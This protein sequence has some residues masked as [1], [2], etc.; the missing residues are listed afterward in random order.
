M[1]GVCQ[2]C[3][4]NDIDLTLHHLIP[5]TCHDNSWFKKRY[6]LDYMKSQTIDVC[7]LCHD[8]IHQIASEKELGRSFNSLDLIKENEEI[9]KF[10]IF[11][12]KQKY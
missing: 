11:A 9:K 1:K 12:R 4:R 5:K 8:K 2:I 7:R 10:I 3:E 6:K